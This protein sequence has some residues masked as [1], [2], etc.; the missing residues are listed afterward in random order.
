MAVPVRVTERDEVRLAV[1]VF[2]RVAENKCVNDRVEVV[3]CVRVV[4]DVRI[5]E[6]MM[7][8]VGTDNFV[9]DEVD[10]CVLVVVCVCEREPAHAC[11]K[12]G[13]HPSRRHT[14]QALFNVPL[15]LTAVAIEACALRESEACRAVKRKEG[16]R[17]AG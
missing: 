7:E 12:T 4:D 13:C 9:D 5:D 8:C 15:S 1:R 3:L 6:D 14:A 17:R 2:V 16:R 10:V 11:S